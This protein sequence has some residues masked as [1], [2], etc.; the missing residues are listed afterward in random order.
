MNI[1]TFKLSK[2]H[3]VYRLKYV[4]EYGKDIFI[5]RIDENKNVIYKKHFKNIKNFEDKFLIESKEFKFIDR[6][7]LNA[8]EIIENKKID[9]FAKSSWIYKQSKDFNMI[10]HKHIFLEMGTEKTKLKTDWT[11]VFYIQIPKN[12]K[13]GEGDIVFMTEDKKLH[14]FKPEENDIIIFAGDLNHMVTQI[15]N[16]EMERIIYASN[17]NL[18][19]KID[20]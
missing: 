10:M 3:V 8:L 6:Y 1:E 19:L 17:I 4:G 5:K 7:V 11:F 12:L 18:N 13:Q 14:A 2:E 16:A 9:K 15:P 20:K